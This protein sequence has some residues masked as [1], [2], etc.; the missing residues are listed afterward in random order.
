MKAIR[1][2]FILFLPLLHWNLYS[3][4]GSKGLVLE[5]GTN[6]NVSNLKWSIA[7]NLDG[8][9]PNILSELKFNKIMSLG[10]YFKGNYAP[11]TYLNLSVFYQQNKV[12]S[13]N[14][15]DTDYKGDNRT[16]PTFEKAFISNKGDFISFKGGIGSPN[17]S[18]YQD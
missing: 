14:G 8:Q 5:T 12:I 6:F 16:N 4:I 15:Y 2:F 3:Q 7:G 10:Y 18:F 17:S 11:V 13:G 1:L 9:S